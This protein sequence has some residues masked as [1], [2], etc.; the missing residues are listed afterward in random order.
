MATITEKR[1]SFH[2]QTETKSIRPKP[3][4]RLILP[5][6]HFI[7]QFMHSALRTPHMM[8]HNC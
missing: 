1:H 7:Y 3:R 8:T 4:P 5:L 2:E 6:K